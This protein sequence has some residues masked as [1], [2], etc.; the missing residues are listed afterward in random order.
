LQQSDENGGFED[1]VVT[2][3]TEARRT[4]KSKRFAAR[5]YLLEARA[6]IGTI[7]GL[8]GSTMGIDLWGRI[9]L[10]GGLGLS[11]GGL[12]LG[13]YV[14]ARP[15]VF[16]SRG[17][18]RLHAI[19]V[20]LGYATGGFT[21]LPLYDYPVAH[22]DW[23]HWIQPGLIY[24]T[25]SWRGFNLLGGI[26]VALPVASSGHHCWEDATSTAPCRHDLPVFPTATIALGYAREDFK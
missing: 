12:Q 18:M 8:V 17:E 5:P 2:I 21:H 14:R 11:T 9:V 20:E 3:P 10:G 22:W 1:V 26:G 19:G 25:R 23:V 7:V 24:E 16:T 6:G 15:F 4:I 13:T